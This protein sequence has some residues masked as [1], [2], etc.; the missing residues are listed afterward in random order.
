[1]YPLR[2]LHTCPSDSTSPC[3]WRPP[4]QTRIKKSLSSTLRHLWSL[5]LPA[6]ISFCQ[7]FCNHTVKTHTLKH[8]WYAV[9]CDDRFAQRQVSTCRCVNTESAKLHLT[10]FESIDESILSIQHRPAACKRNSSRFVCKMPRHRFSHIKLRSPIC[11][12][13]TKTLKARIRT[14]SAAPNSRHGDK[15]NVLHWNM[16]DKSVVTLPSASGRTIRICHQADLK[17]KLA[18]KPLP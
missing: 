2:Q 1:L 14:G 4:R 13:T 10:S 11:F 8:I 18:M 9:F 17:S 16:A 5:S 7:H 12:V 3:A 6:V 15:M